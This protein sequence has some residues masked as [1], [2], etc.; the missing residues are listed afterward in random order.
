MQPTIITELLKRPIAYNPIVA[1]AFGSVKLGILWSQLYYWQDKTRDKEG[2][3]YK[4]QQ[5]IYNETGLS[6]KEQETA[7]KI[8]RGLL[9]L[10]EK[11]AGQPATVHFRLDLKRAEAIIREFYEKEAHGQVTLIEIAKKATSS[12][13]YL[14]D[15]P[16]KDVKE[17]AE[18]F[19][20]TEEFVR[21]RVEDVLD[22]CEASGKRY[23][24]YKAALRNFIKNHRGEEK[25]KKKVKRYFWGEEM[26]YSR[27]KWWVIPKEGGPWKLFGGKLEDTEVR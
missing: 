8:G 19:K 21:A 27:N 25:A 15:I 17:L 6:R 16:E 26:V 5:A 4:T 10:E 18:K 1:K 9:V 12:I 13:A 7:R 14:K 2:W 3:I 11:L 24:N 22:Y 23:K 20:K